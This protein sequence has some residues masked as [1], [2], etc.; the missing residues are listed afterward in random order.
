MS[1][2]LLQLSDCHLP[3]QAGQRVHGRDADAG[4]AALV[5]RLLELPP[6]DHILLSGDL[7]HHSGSDA[8]L[9]L[10]QLIEPLAGER[11]WLPGNH[12]DIDLMRA[13]DKGGKLGCKEVMLDSRWTLLQLDTT[14]RPDGRGSGAL[15]GAELN[16]LQERLSALQDRYL[17]LALHH[18]P[19]A[20]GSRWQDEI[21]LGNPEALQRLLEQAP[22]VQGL[23][24]GHVHQALTL[25][26][27]HR[28]LWSAPSTLVQFARGCETFT[29]E[30]DPELSTPGCRWYEL[31]ADGSIQAHEVWLSTGFEEKWP[32]V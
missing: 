21:R 25:Q 9:R 5:A 18:N 12:D 23:V 27:V 22:Q 26:F 2:R 7:A 17:L 8:Y 31:E 16:W 15:A 3:A 1:V 10:L 28:P 4:L 24:C 29:L 32:H 11:H 20:T 14:A 30:T 13:V 19:V 6:F